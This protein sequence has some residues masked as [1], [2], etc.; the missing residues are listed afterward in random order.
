LSGISSTAIV[1]LRAGSPTWNRVT[2]TGGTA[3]AQAESDRANAAGR[4]I[5][6][7]IML[8]S[9]RMRQ[10][11]TTPGGFSLQTCEAMAWLHGE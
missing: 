8:V 9:D 5:C 1:P 10:P 3:V 6:F 4:R 7:I 11:Y 2:S